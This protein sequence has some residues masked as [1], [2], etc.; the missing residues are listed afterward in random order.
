MPRVSA[1]AA[2]RPE[3]PLI[4]AAPRRAA[5][6]AVVISAVTA[7]LAIAGLLLGTSCALLAAVAV[8]RAQRA[9]RRRHGIHDAAPQEAVRPRGPAMRA[10]GGRR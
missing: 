10:R 1:R 9:W 6:I 5:G 3:E 2:P 7:V 8:D 4:F